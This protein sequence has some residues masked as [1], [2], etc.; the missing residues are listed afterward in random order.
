M[1]TISVNIK[2]PSDIFKSLNE[3]EEEFKKELTLSAAAW[4]YKNERLSLAKAASL[5]GYYR[6][7][8]ENFLA[9]NNIPVSLQSPGDILNDVKKI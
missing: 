4:L 9:A 1:E 8:F 7:D 3:S 5:A 2:V 6:Y